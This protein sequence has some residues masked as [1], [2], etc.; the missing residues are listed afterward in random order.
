MVNHFEYGGGGTNSSLSG[1][2]Q[3]QTGPT[4]I[5]ATSCNR[6]SIPNRLVPPSSQICNHCRKSFSNKGDRD[7]H[8]REQHVYGKRLLCHLTRCPHGRAG[9]G[10]TRLDKLVSHLTSG[11]HKM[12]YKKAKREA[13]EH[14]RDVIAAAN[15]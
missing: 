7:R 2:L 14:N 5:G 3:S 15:E 6:L 9:R 10:F 13:T 12:G 8:V 1:G 4:E 11:K